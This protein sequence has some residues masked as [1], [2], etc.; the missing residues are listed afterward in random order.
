MTHTLTQSG[1]HVDKKLAT[2]VENELLPGTHLTAEQFWQHFAYI[3]KTLTPINKQ[4]LAKREQLQQQIDDYHLNNKPWD[5]EHYKQFLHDIGYLVPQ[6][7]AFEIETQNVEPEIAHTAG[8]QLVVPV[9]NARF[10]IN[11]ANARWGSLYDALYGTDILSEED[12]AEKANNYNPVRGFKVMAYARQFLDKALPLSNGSH[13]ESTNYSVVNGALIITLRDSSQ[14]TLV[15]PSQLIGYQGE[16]QNPS[17]I[18]F[19]NNGLHLELHIDHHHM[20]GQ[21]DKAGIK[22]IV[23]EA[24]ITT[25][26]DCEDSVAAVDAEDKINVYKNWLGLMK[27][28]LV[29]SFKK[30]DH[31]IERALQSDKNYT[32]LDG[33]SV[34]LKGRS[35]MFVRNVG[36]LMTNPAIKDADNNPV[37]EGIMDAFFTATAALHDLNKKTGTKNTLVNP[38]HNISQNSLCVIFKFGLNIFFRQAI[39]IIYKRWGE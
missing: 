24:A 26:M 22:D 1:F 31:L 10:A 13:I 4:L 2:F 15:N 30:A 27:G 16:A 19:K 12:G 39:S 28:N 35:L 8:P 7:A 33:K 21:A 23:L 6:P 25:I 18:L 34:T 29:E 17:L 14:T 38:A 32:S 9:S 37:F 20:I 11:A 5:N 36:H 3:V